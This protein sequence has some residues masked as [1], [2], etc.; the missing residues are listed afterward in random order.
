MLKFKKMALVDVIK[1]IIKKMALVDL[2]IADINSL[3]AWEP[4]KKNGKML[5]AQ[6]SNLEKLVTEL[7]KRC[8]KIDFPI[9][10]VLN[11]LVD[12][13]MPIEEASQR[14]DEW[15]GIK[16]ECSNS[17]T[18]TSEPILSR[19]ETFIRDVRS[20]LDDS[21]SDYELSVVLGNGDISTPYWVSI[22]ESDDHL[23]VWDNEDLSSSANSGF[24][25]VGYKDNH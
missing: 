9:F 3:D 19:L 12:N 10:T 17:A 20:N 5:D 16:I 23:K 11:V 21:D 8:L 7:K 15:F 24:I 4:S 1:T 6:Y 13:G 25:W 18:E 14:I 22:A 2:K